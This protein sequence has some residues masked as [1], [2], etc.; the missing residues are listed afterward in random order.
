M[1]C[2]ADTDL[3]R[4]DP[5][6]PGLATLLDLDAFAAALRRAV[7]GLEVEGGRITYV[8]YKPATSC[9][10]GYRLAAAGKAVVVAA[11]AYRPDAADKLAKAGRRPGLGRVALGDRAIVVWFFP[12]DDELKVLLR[13]EDGEAR[14]EL[15]R[16]LLPA[17]PDLW[18][19]VLEPLQY[20]PA[21]RYVGRLCTGGTPRAVLR[22]YT[23]AGY[24]A[25]RVRSEAS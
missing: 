22:A 5:A 21:R 15:L 14:T 13:L 1:L 11:A 3:V 20:K 17:R 10:V 19:G 2:P 6:L 4:R 7:P 16:Q 23:R 24:E 18:Q 8:R 9:L 12:D 25:A